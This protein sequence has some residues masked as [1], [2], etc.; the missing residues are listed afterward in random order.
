MTSGQ[1]LNYET[2]DEF[3]IKTLRTYL[4]KYDIKYSLSDAFSMKHFEMCL[5]PEEV[6]QINEFLDKWNA[7]QE[8]VKE[9]I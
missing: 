1:W 3:I 6:K 5:E 9:V 8:W 7:V 2:N 4:H